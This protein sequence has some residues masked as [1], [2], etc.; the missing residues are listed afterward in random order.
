[1]PEPDRLQFCL[2]Y[3]FSPLE[4]YVPLAR[5]ADAHGWDWAAVSDHVVNP[6]TI[7]SKY[8]YSK[9]GERRWQHFTE[10]ADPWVA[11]GAMAAA[12]ERLRFTTNVYVLPM[13]PPAAVAK[14][15]ATAA[16]LS[17]GRV[18]L[19]VGMGWMAE[20]FEVMEQPFAKRGARADEM[21]EVLR[22]L[23][24]G[25]WVEHHG[26][27]YDFAPLEM[28]PSP[29]SVPIFVGG[30]SEPALRRAA[31]NDGW[32]SD[33][34][35]TEELAGFCAKLRAYRDELGRGD[36]PFA[37]IASCKDAWDLDGYRR[38]HEVGVTHLL[39]QPWMFYAGDTKD[40][41]ERIDGIARFADDIISRW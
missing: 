36:E 21:I 9:T 25:G 4:Q 30:T 10:F 20:E 35:T 19:G 37:V 1:M 2:G 15:V 18:A 32:V 3:G 11:I 31:R 16:A 40:L 17:G 7:E 22:K 23:W 38:L 26:A 41:G 6:E 12:T 5:A 8:P 28:T 24:A 39:T 13:R 33:L 27:H 29:G 34:Q 14:V